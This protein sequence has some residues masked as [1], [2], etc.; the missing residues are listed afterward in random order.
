MKKIIL[1]FCLL[2]NVLFFAQE[3]ENLEP[4]FN[5]L[6]NSNA[7]NEQ[8][9]LYNNLY[10]KASDNEMISLYN[11]SSITTK[12]ALE[13]LDN[14]DLENTAN[15]IQKEKNPAINIYGKIMDVENNISDINKRFTYQ[16]RY[17][18]I[19]EITSET[20][21][22][23]QVY[24]KDY[25]LPNDATMFVY[26]AKGM[27]VLGAFTPNN[28][29]T[30]KVNDGYAFMTQ[31]VIG[32]KI[33]IEL[34][35]PVTSNEVPILNL[36]SIVH[37][38]KG[39]YSGPYGTAGNCHKNVACLFNG[40]N[41]RGRSI[42]SVGLILANYKS[43]GN[44]A[45]SCSGALMNNTRQDGTPYFLT[46]SHCVGAINTGNYNWKNEFL[47]L[48]NYE[49]KLCNDTIV[50]ATNTLSK[51]SILGA[52]LMI[53]S[54]QDWKDFAL[55]KLRTTKEVLA[56]YK[57][58]YAGWDNAPLAY[59]ANAF[60]R[61]SVHHPK[62]DV[63]KISLVKDIFP[64]D[65]YFNQYSGGDYLAVSWKDGIV[66]QGSSGS[67]LFN[68]FDRVIGNLSKG[69]DPQIFNCNNPDKYTDPYLITTYSRFSNNFLLMKQW[70][71]PDF[72]SAQSI[73]PF[74]SS[75]INISVPPTYNPPINIDYE[76]SIDI[77]RAYVHPSQTF[78][79]KMYISRDNYNNDPTIKISSDNIIS[80][81]SNLFDQASNTFRINGIY[82]VINCNKLQYI[83]DSEIVIE[84]K[85]PIPNGGVSGSIIGIG[86]NRVVI[87]LKSTSGNNYNEEIQTF[88]IEGKK[89]VFESWKTLFENITNHSL[90]VYYENNHLLVFNKSTKTL[91]S[92][93][94][95]NG[96]WTQGGQQSFSDF[97]NV[98]MIDD[99]FFVSHYDFSNTP[100]AVKNKMSVFAFQADS[101]NYNLI[102]TFNNF[103]K[104]NNT[105]S[106]HAWGVIDISKNKNNP[107]IFY[108]SYRHKPQGDPYNRI[109]EINLSNQTYTHFDLGGD[110]NLE[111]NMYNWNLFASHVTDDKIIQF[112]SG[113]INTGA[114][115][116]VRITAFKKNPSTGVW[117]ID[118]YQ[119]FFQ[120]LNY[121]MNDKYLIQHTGRMNGPNTNI[122]N[123]REI[124]LLFHPETIWSGTNSSLNTASYNM[125]R[126]LT[127]NTFWAG[128]S[129]G[130]DIYSNLVGFHNF[131]PFNHVHL[132]NFNE[133]SMSQDNKAIILSDHTKPITGQKI[134]KASGKYFI[135]MKPGFSIA[136]SSGTE[137]EARPE[138]NINNSNI[139]ACSFTFDDMI[140][141]E[142]GM[143]SQ[144]LYLRQGNQDSPYY[145]EIIYKQKEEDKPILNIDYKI[146][147]NPTNGI[148][149]VDFNGEKFKTIEVY[150][151]EGK[152]IQNINVVA[153][154]KV[155][156][157]L[158]EYPTGIYFIKLIKLNGMSYSNKII[159]K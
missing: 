77:N 115:P 22:S 121:A 155:D 140:N 81:K 2:L 47:V 51:N 24:F 82:K 28:N 134:V 118:T 158:T 29:P 12:I 60:D 125:M 71:D 52:D 153:K 25:N 42:K 20:A 46:A 138:K 84:M 107:N 85:H 6:L 55:L 124:D 122:L 87:K 146:Y 117:Q 97:I 61:Y 144:Q 62:G 130:K 3:S 73:G 17:Y 32:N 129:F 65:I 116:A 59:T 139:P 54:S 31:P 89:L 147:P 123:I 58:C 49:T 35:Y 96:N 39:F 30:T 27:M 105:L 136:A 137:F 102:N 18:N 92:W 57:V 95:S 75:T 72:T 11:I 132:N 83:D 152:K 157:N 149:S 151:T 69:R 19:V 4:S 74:C 126:D 159:K 148:L 67:P 8:K 26:D 88:K 43:N 103:Y 94:L 40:F 100:S 68:S 93:F 104:S 120:N 142:L 141:P 112:R 56:R 21:Q 119:T 114:G 50:E 86:N 5:I 98:K 10:L 34:S 14:I 106:T 7:S 33:F 127:Y 135:H 44:F 80:T 110:L 45:F 9:A 91:Y 64:A 156:I 78:G 41:D 76:K 99:K 133:G 63:K 109:L 66:E 70:L 154:I 90:D 145:G 48:F 23:L 53:D 128:I 131:F 101:P 16:D 15:K 111:F 36:K 38:F 113:S 150:S 13:N 79:K 143:F 1:Q 108:I 37:G